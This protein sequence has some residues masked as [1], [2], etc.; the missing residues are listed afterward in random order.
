MAQKQSDGVATFD[1]PQ[2]GEITGSVGGAQLPAIPC[3]MVMF[4]APKSNAGNVYLGWSSGIT[5]TNQ[6]T[7]TT[8]GYQLLPGDQTPW[9]PVDNLNRLWRI[10]DNAG[11]SLVYILLD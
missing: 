3:R 6:T 2:T 7:T 5:K 9:L 8:A 4:K 11:D 10:T 1:A